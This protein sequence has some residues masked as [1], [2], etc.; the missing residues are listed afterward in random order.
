VFNISL[1]N[2]IFSA[3]MS[4]GSNLQNC[5]EF[6]VRGLQFVKYHIY[7]VKSKPFWYAA[8]SA[9]NI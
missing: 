2:S 8:D 1:A 7:Y 9:D 5:L 6:A 3:C 4:I